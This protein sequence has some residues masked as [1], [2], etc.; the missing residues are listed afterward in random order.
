VTIA[1]VTLAA[2]LTTGAPHLLAAED[3]AARPVETAGLPPATDDVEAHAELPAPLSEEDAAR[4]AEIMALQEDGKWRE[5]D[6]LIAKVG[7]RLLMG[8][9]LAQRY[10]HPTKY[11]SRYAELA[12]W[13]ADYADHPQARQIYTLALTRK[14]RK[15]RAPRSPAW[16]SAGGTMAADALDSSRNGLRIRGR[17]AAIESRVRALVWQTRLTAAEDYLARPEI[18]G[19]LSAAEMDSLR[20]RIA[21]GWFL[22][23]NDENALRLVAPAARRS[24]HLVPAAR[25]TAGLAA[26]RSG[27][28]EDA[29]AHF[30]AMAKSERL[31]RWNRP[32]AAFWA[33]RANMVGRRPDRVSHWLG[34]AANEPR[35]F[36]GILARRVMGLDS[37]LRWDRPVLEGEHIAALNASAGAQRALALIQIDEPRQAERELRLLTGAE[38]PALRASLLAVSE[39]ASLPSLAMGVAGAIAASGGKRLDRG[40]YPVPHW[41]PEGGFKVDRAL[42]YA[43]MRQESAFKV[44]AK[45]HAGARGLMQLMPATAGYMANTRFRGRGRDRLFD[46]GLNIALGQKYLDYLIRHDQVQ[47][48]VFLLAAAYNGGPGNLA[49]WQRRVGKVTSDPLMFIESIP[50]RETRLFIERVLA[51]L[52]IYRERLGQ[53]RP[54]LD[55]IAAG[56]RPVYKALDNVEVADAETDAGKN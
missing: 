10:L 29:V 55:A 20:T 26:Y 47:G 37:G 24:G 46:P 40:F 28:H 34:I 23:G 22:Y 33:A 7:N 12:K 51:N 19:A 43:F 52:W 6:R 14:P 31:G 38:D 54:S 36:Y 1:A 42:I 30:E 11:R 17:A 48:D 21:S 25:W 41:K 49:K 3:G 16:S 27:R 4:Y 5:A 50:S 44:R 39:E 56:T 53:D 35:T 18:R 9:V 2:A 15:A 8:H 13:M 32:A 45:S